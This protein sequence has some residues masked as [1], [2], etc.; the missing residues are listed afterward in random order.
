[1]WGDDGG[2]GQGPEQGEGTKKRRRRRGGRLRSEVQTSGY[3]C[4]GERESD[5]GADGGARR[6]P[7]CWDATAKRLRRVNSRRWTRW[8]RP[9]GL[10]ER[11]RWDSWAPGRQPAAAHRAR[12]SGGGLL[13]FEE[14][15]TLGGISICHGIAAAR[16]TMRTRPGCGLWEWR[17]DLRSG[18]HM[19]WTC[20]VLGVMPRPNHHYRNRRPRVER[21]VVGDM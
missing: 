10:W 9:G 1:M 21:L 13:P 18:K 3:F 19:R 6:R 2:Q 15:T 4:D 17:A 8:G 14:P 20:E 16:T 5:V 12:A 11:W 7:R